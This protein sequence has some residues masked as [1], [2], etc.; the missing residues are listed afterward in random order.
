MK[1][2][3][4]QTILISSLMLSIAYARDQKKGAHPHNP[5]MKEAFDTCAKQAKMPDR[6]SGERPTKE[7]HEAMKAC[8]ESKGITPP[9]HGP[10]GPAGHH[11]PDD[12]P[13]PPMQQTENDN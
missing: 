5:E 7:Q 8:L 10:G 3:I 11:G 4:T 13:M 2:F 1:S 9:Q 12:L 6:D